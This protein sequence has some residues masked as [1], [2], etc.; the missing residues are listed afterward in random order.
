MKGIGIGYGGAK[1]KKPEHN[2]SKA[3]MA[4][5][6]YKITARRSGPSIIEAVADGHRYLAISLLSSEIRKISGERSGILAENGDD[7]GEGY[8]ADSS[9]MSGDFEAEKS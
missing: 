9:G 7:D 4:Y 6:I 2:V 5:V 3:E 1:A 8:I